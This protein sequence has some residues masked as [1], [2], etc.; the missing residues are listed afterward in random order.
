MLCGAPRAADVPQIHFFLDYLRALR[1]WRC[2]ETNTARTEHFDV[3][4]IGAIDR[5]DWAHN[6]QTWQYLA[7]LPND[8]LKVAGRATV[9][10]IH[11]HRA[12]I[13]RNLPDLLK[14]SVSPTISCDLRR[15]ESL[16]APDG[17][18]DENEN[19]RDRNC[20]S[21]RPASQRM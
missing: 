4:L 2:S 6:P 21:A 15:A 8:N 11:H 1:I 17:E 19:K 7:F 16:S 18:C 3:C 10:Q 13:R 5:E 9:A 12:A 20:D 14:A